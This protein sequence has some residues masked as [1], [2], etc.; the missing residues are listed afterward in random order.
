MTQETNPLESHELKVLRQQLAEAQQRLEACEQHALVMRQL[1]NNLPSQIYATSSTG[2]ILFVNTAFA[3]QQGK[4]PADFEGH[5]LNDLFSP[6]IAASWQQNI[7]NFMHDAQVVKNQEVYGEGE[8][9]LYYDNTRF[10]IYDIENVPIALGGFA[11][12]VTDRMR[13]EA[14]YADTLLILNGI[15]N[16][17]PAVIYV[18]NPENRLLLVN[19]TYAAV[20]GQSI[21]N[22]VGCTEY[23]L[24]P[25]EMV[26]AWRESDCMLFEHGQ[27]LRYP[28][29]FVIDGEAR[30]FL[31]VQF[32]LYDN[33]HQ[34]YAICGLSTD[35]TDLHRSERERAELQTQII[36]AQRIALRELNTPLIPLANDVVI[37]PLIG[38]IDSTR[39]AQV[40]ETLLEGVSSH[41]AQL[42]ILD[43]TGLPVVDSQ[44]ANTLLHA[45]QAVKLLGAEVLLTGI[46]PEVAQT[47]VGIGADLS[48]IK[49]P[50]TLQAGINY[51][52]RKRR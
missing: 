5:T 44:V 26:D 11:V 48:G 28:N 13:A 4:T 25:A 47:L 10:P 14:K 41:H 23:D 15:I 34:P 43:I 35:V 49:T 36:E 7:D 2:T 24:F 40:M 42:A 12:D 37:M 17:S 38:S 16:N 8:K 20:L 29:T 1:L 30:E 31:T 27:P 52:L 9:A 22:L 46:G 50:G 3:A 19:Q 51:A 32:P 33:E 18:K 45:A 6:E 39:A 21:E